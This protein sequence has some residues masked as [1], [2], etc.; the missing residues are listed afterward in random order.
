MRQAVFTRPLTITLSEDQY[1]KIKTISDEQ[2]I[3]M[4]DLIRK[5]LDM[6][7]TEKHIIGGSNG[8]GTI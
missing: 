1:T 3:S 4:S 7:F 6:A 2:R 5:V 8:N